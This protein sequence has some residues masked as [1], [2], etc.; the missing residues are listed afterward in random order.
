MGCLVQVPVETG[1][2]LFRGLDAG[3]ESDSGFREAFAKVFGEAPGRARGTALLTA[4][5]IETPL[6]PMLANRL[7]F[8]PSVE[9]ISVDATPQPSR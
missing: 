2:V 9:G 1:S 5:W 3:F 8:A 6:G 4:S 7:A